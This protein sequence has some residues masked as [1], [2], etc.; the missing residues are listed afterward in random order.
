MTSHG[1]CE[2]SCQVI[3]LFDGKVLDDP[4]MLAQ[5]EQ[6]LVE[7]MWNTPI[8]YNVSRP[9]LH[10]FLPDARHATGVGIII[11]P[12]GAF[13]A[14][15][16]ENEGNEVA[17]WVSIHGIAGFVLHYRLIPCR[18]NDPTREPIMFSPKFLQQLQEILPLAM[19]DG[20]R[21]MEI[22]RA[23]ALKYLVDPAKVGI[24]GF[25][26]GGA[27]TASVMHNYAASSKPAF[28]ALVY[29]AFYEYVPKPKGVPPDA[30]PVFLVAASDDELGLAHQTV[31][32]YNAWIRAGKIAEMHIYSK[33]GHG[34]GMRKQGLPTDGWPE[35][36]LDFLKAEGF[37]TVL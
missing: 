35:R 18:S 31:E 15:S 28:A 36:L 24:L 5:W 20:L 17:R 25:S 3:D 9:T 2:K 22:V 4:K 1:G 30:P 27:V 8:V 37:V 12:G 19:S 16:I 21:A 32:I 13:V 6:T 34:F 33:G 11:C 29:P 14:L 26:A 7:N 10:A 23:N